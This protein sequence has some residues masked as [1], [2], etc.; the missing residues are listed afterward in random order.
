[1]SNTVQNGKGSKRRQENFK[2]LQSNWDEINWTRKK[3]SDKKNK[4]VRGRKKSQ[5]Y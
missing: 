1:M 4:P 3:K 2:Q 5:L